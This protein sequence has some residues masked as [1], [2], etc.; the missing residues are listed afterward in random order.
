MEGTPA[1]A[2]AATAWSSKHWLLA[3]CEV[4]QKTCLA[5][6]TSA[7]IGWRSKNV[8]CTGSSRVKVFGRLLKTGGA[9][10]VASSRNVA[11]ARQARVPAGSLAKKMVPAGNAGTAAA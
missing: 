10:P 1:A 4:P 3:G 5:L 8:G 6:E 9:C 7:N 2:A 11:R